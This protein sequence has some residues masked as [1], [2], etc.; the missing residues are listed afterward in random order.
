MI[1]LRRMRWAGHVERIGEMTD[2]Y[3]DLVGKP[4]GTRPLERSLC[5]WQDN[6]K[7]VFKEIGCEC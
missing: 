6:I 4:E 1:I 2:L 7:F 3:T 5:R